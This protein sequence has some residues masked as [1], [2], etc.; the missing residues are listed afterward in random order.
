MCSQEIAQGNE[1]HATQWQVWGWN[2][3]SV[4]PVNLGTW[5]VQIMDHWLVDPAPFHRIEL[6]Q[7]YNA[8]SPIGVVA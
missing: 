2:I 5:D 3:E 4:A 8:L 7:I 6:V 1:R